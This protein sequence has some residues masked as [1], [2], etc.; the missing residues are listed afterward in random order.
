M[1][2]RAVPSA[3][4]SLKVNPAMCTNEDTFSTEE[5]EE[6][7]KGRRFVRLEMF[8]GALCAAAGS[9]VYVT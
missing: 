3:A 6:D 1:A 4:V 5:T 7:F 2:P 8:S 9:R